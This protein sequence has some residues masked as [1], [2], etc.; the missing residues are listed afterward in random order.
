MNNKM[1]TF[2]LGRIK[3]HKELKLTKMP[4]SV[5][6]F[7]ANIATTKAEYWIINRVTFWMFAYDRTHQWTNKDFLY[8]IN[9]KAWEKAKEKRKERREAKRAYALKQH[10]KPR[11]YMEAADLTSWEEVSGKG[12]QRALKELGFQ[13]M[14]E[15]LKGFS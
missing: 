7:G 1:Y 9:E 12:A 2:H 8:E 13:T 11:P 3:A 15:A 10:N 6:E 4:K 5:R 14:E